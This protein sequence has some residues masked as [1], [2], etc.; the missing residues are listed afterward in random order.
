MRSVA[1]KSL[2]Y[3]KRSSTSS[4]AGGMAGRR[5]A[6]MSRED[7]A[8]G[9]VIS[10][11]GKLS[12]SWKR[13]LEKERERE[14]EKQRER[15]LERVRRRPRTPNL[16]AKEKVVVESDP[17]SEGQD[18][19]ADSHT[20]ILRRKRGDHVDVEDEE[21][22]LEEVVL[23]TPKQWVASAS[24]QAGLVTSVPATATQ[25]LPSNSTYP[26]LSRIPSSRFLKTS[27]SSH[28]FRTQHTMDTDTDFDFGSPTPPPQLFQSTSS[29]RPRAHSHSTS[30]ARSLASSAYTSNTARTASS[31]EKPT[32]DEMTVIDFRRMENRTPPAMRGRGR[33]EDVRWP[34]QLKPEPEGKAR[35]FFLGRREPLLGGDQ[36]GR[37][38]S[39]TTLKVAAGT[40]PTSGGVTVSPSPLSKLFSRRERERDKERD[41][42]AAMT[43]P[44]IVP[45]Q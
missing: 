18:N 11:S 8:V 2:S 36:E 35:S 29:S 14:R 19:S 9:T 31:S 4:G 33:E 44:G 1:G 38:P 6:M 7:T 39:E 21:G 43:M 40:T 42:E 23:E 5:L 32:R 15:E 17:A 3:S 20:P 13:K 25:P 27:S 45:W 30:I 28:S 10:G 26:P 24:G 41:L 22:P 16:E 12:K 34:S 37:R